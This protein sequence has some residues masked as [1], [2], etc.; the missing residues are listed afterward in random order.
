M[1]CTF[2]KEEGL[3]LVFNKKKVPEVFFSMCGR[4]GGGEQM[5]A[6]VVLCCNDITEKLCV[7]HVWGLLDGKV[8]FLSCVW[9]GLRRRNR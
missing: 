5:G 2:R 9:E 6:R 3:Y 8:F 4:V 7:Q 1:M